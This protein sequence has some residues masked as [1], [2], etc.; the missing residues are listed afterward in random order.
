[1]AVSGAL[2]NDAFGPEA[3]KIISAA[4]EETLRKLRLVDRTDLLTTLVARKMIEIA[5]EGE[6]D[7]VRLREQTLR[8]LRS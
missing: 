6:L 8:A 1:M 4:F 3:I 7:P 5:R 2:R